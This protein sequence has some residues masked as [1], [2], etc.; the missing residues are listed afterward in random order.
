MSSSSVGGVGTITSVADTTL[1]ADSSML[2]MSDNTLAVN[3]LL[4]RIG[5]LT[6]Q[7][8]PNPA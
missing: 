5:P 4:P 7:P 8:S 3:A 2:V 6:R 1:A